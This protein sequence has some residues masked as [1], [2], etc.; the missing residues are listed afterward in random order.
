MNGRSFC[1]RHACVLECCRTD[2]TVEAVAARFEERASQRDN[3]LH[4]RSPCY[5]PRWPTTIV[6]TTEMT[7]G[8]VEEAV[9]EEAAERGRGIEVRGCDRLSL[10][11]VL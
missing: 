11:V 1:L 3:P 8:M 6:A 4:F 5:Q 2:V 10:W 9:E 7:G